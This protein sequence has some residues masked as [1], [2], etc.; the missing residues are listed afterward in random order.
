MSCTRSTGGLAPTRAAELGA[1]HAGD[2]PQGRFHLAP[3]SSA[4][5]MPAARSRTRSGVGVGVGAPVAG[6]RAP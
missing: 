6:K 5:G 3:T 2:A 4:Q 1:G